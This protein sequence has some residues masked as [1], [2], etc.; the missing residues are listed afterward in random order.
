MVPSII[1]SAV[2]VIGTITSVIFVPEVSIKNRKFSIFWLFPLIAAI[3]S[4]AIGTISIE[5][6]WSGLTNDMFSMLEGRT[7]VNPIKIILLFYGMT[8][9]SVF[10]DET[11]VFRYV[12]SKSVALASKSQTKLFFLLFAMV[13]L[14]TI[15]TSNDVIILTFTPFICYFCKNAKISPIPYIVSEFV[16]ANTFSMIFVIGNPTNIYLAETYGTTFF[17]YFK[18]MAIPSLFAGFTALA[19]LYILFSKKLKEPISTDNFATVKIEKPF[20]AGFTLVIL[21]LSLVMLVISDYIGIEMWAVAVVSML[22]LV[23]GALIFALKSHNRPL[24]L[25]RTFSRLP[26]QLAPFV[27]SMFVLV[28]SLKEN[29]VTDYIIDALSKIDPKYDILVYG[30]SSTV[31]SN[32]INNIPMS[33]LYSVLTATGSP[34]SMYASVIGSNIGAFLTPIGALAGI[35]FTGLLRDLDVKFSFVEFIKYGVCVAVPTLFAAIGGLYIS[36]LF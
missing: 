6:V 26:Y 7:S 31:V 22:V 33:V 34:A 2:A 18:I 23:C 5:K 25:S 28:L 20:L 11:G 35:M 24:E 29:G 1:L 9:I 16:A 3:L 15:F 10:L 8:S 14:L 27:L 19:V 13:S 36:M 32:L 4:V 17:G 21:F 30:V 12:A